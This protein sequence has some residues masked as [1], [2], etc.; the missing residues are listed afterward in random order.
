MSL[1]YEYCRYSQNQEDGIIDHLTNAIKK[2]NKICV[3]MGWGNDRK[4][5]PE[6]DVA[7][8]CTQN[9]VQKKGYICYAYDPKR[10]IKIPENVIFHQQKVIPSEIDTYLNTFPK[11]V[12]FFS[13]D[14]DSYDFEMMQGLIENG[15]KPKIICA[16]INRRLGNDIFFSMPF[17]ENGQYTKTLFHG[18]SI[19]KCRTY[20]ESKRYKFFTLDSTHLN[21][22]FYLED[23]LDES[24]LSK[25]Y[26]DTVV[27]D[28]ILTTEQFQIEIENNEYWKDK[29]AYDLF[30]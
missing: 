15:F 2:Q 9:L 1:S 10:Q 23:E 14:I 27:F 19:K 8:N 28:G 7:V 26:E 17:Y 29:L 18:V 11:D 16:E 12:D 4:T 6:L 22:F 5:R 25:E 24:L 21:A 30:K 3:E 13:L 20:L